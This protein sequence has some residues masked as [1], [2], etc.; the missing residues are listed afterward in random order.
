MQPIEMKGRQRPSL[1]EWL[2]QLRE[3][4]PRR[5][6][7]KISADRETSA[8]SAAARS[9]EQKQLMRLLRGDL[10]WIAMKALERDRE[11]RYG[12]PAEL[13]AELRRYL[14]DEPVVARPAS[15]AYQ[16]GKLIRRHRIAT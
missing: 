1:E 15:F 10:D 14:N 5:P 7:S 16:L 3:E 8:E 11:R 2:R 6:S 9:T 12:T 13:A 4:E